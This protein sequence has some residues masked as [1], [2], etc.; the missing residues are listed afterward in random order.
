MVLVVLGLIAVGA[1]MLLIYYSITPGKR[2]SDSEH[3]DRRSPAREKQYEK[4]DDGKVVYLYNRNEKSGGDGKTETDGDGNGKE[5]DSE[6]GSDT[7]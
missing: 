3:G 6:K 5:D 7:D 1:A 4:S 2:S